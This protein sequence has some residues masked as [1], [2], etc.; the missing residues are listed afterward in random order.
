MKS[1]T[2]ICED[3]NKKKFKIKAEELIF[4]PSVYGL[5]FKGDKI[6]LSKQWDGYDFPGGGLKKGELIAEALK[7]EFWEETGLRIMPDK[8]VTV[9]D[10]FF[11]SIES[12]KSLQ[13]ILIYYICKNP[14][15]RISM[16]NCDVHEKIYMSE[17][18]WINI[19]DIRKI[20]FYNGVDSVK[21]IKQAYAMFKKK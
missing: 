20:K 13:G 11:I 16:A 2:V 6:L 3:I 15:G 12:R 7:R 10:S 8:L 9:A 21:L 17:A 14:R 5:L 4:R 18:E 19:K 1:K